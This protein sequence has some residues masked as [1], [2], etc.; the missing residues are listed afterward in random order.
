M[1]KTDTELWQEILADNGKSWEELIKRYQA[2]VYAVS[3]RAGLTMMDAADCFQQTWLLLYKNRKKLRDPSRLSAWLVT[4]AKREA[5]LLRRR[6]E[7]DSGIIDISSRQNCDNPPGSELELISP[8]PLPDEELEQIENQARIEIALDELD[9]RCQQVM[10]A[11]FFAPESKTYEEI[12]KSFS[13]S[14]NSLGPLR[15]RC[16]QRLKEILMK[17]WDTGER[18]NN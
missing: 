17:N 3:T 2:L 10:E 7:K 6:A 4:T 15:R 12:A 13:I 16:L 8:G 1:F 5:L 9:H 18:K 14:S 11:F